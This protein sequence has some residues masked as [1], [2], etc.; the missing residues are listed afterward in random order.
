MENKERTTKN[1]ILLGSGLVAVFIVLTV[2]SNAIY[3]GLFGYGVPVAEGL[4][5]CNVLG[6]NLHG[7][8]YTYVPTEG[9]ADDPE[10]YQNQYGDA[11]GS[12]DIV[13][14]L[15]QADQDDQ[16]KA[17]IVEVDSGGGFPVAGEEISNTIKE[18]TKPVVAVIRQSGMSAAYW[19]IS[20]S[21]KIF[22]SRN[23][24]VGSIGVT[25]SY[26]ENTSKDT[27]YIQLSSGKFKDTG[28]PDKPLSEEERNLLL[29][30]IKI[31]HENFIE[32]IAQNRKLSVESVKA[33]ADGSSV[34]GERAKALGLIDE[35]GSWA[36]AEKYLEETIGE[37]PEIC[38]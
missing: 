15:R 30:D 16:I 12:E 28:S 37:K 13:G 32:D 7:S 19:A 3:N 36:T 24:D 2:A 18:L 20:S 35:I 6:I 22:A 4:D 25:S 23:S 11:V 27:K 10:E 29:R 38:W 26:L 33:I 34:L 14:Q 21:D 8:L 17:I 9:S 1:K 31:T 5:T